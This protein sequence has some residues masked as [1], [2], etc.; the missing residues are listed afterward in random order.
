MQTYICECVRV[1][2]PVMGVSAVN[3]ARIPRYIPKNPR[4]WYISRNVAIIEIAII[5]A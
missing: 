1:H 4:A 2:Q 5:P 3:G